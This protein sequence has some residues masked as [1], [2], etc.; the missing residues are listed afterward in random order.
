MNSSL[1]FLRGWR[2]LDGE[3][4]LQRAVH[5]VQ[6]AL[7]HVAGAQG[8][9]ARGRPR[10][11]HVARLQS[12]E[13]RDVRHQV[14]DREDHVAR[15]LVLRNRKVERSFC[16]T[17]YHYDSGGIGAVPY[18]LELAVH[19]HPDAGHL[20]GGQLVLGYELAHGAGRVEGL[21]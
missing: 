7:D 1:P 20:W 3:L 12:H 13:V 16:E 11:D 2:C 21:G 6:A 5:R 19:S 10:Q 15:A 17:S 8:T 4:E 14:R 9:G 18:L